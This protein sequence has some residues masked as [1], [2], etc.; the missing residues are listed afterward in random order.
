MCHHVPNP[1]WAPASPV[2]PAAKVAAAA[3]SDDADVIATAATAAAGPLRQDLYKAIEVSSVDA[4]QVGAVAP[5]TMRPPE[6]AYG[7]VPACIC[8]CAHALVCCVSLGRAASSMETGQPSL[9]WSK[10]HQTV[11]CCSVLLLCCVAVVCWCAGVLSLHHAGA[12]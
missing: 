9:C 10:P 8:M 2:A 12:G 1:A 5:C 7:C 6:Q 4:F 3:D 11:R